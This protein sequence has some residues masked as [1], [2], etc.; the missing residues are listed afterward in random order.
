[1]VNPLKEQAVSKYP[2]T[3]YIPTGQMLF[4]QEAHLFFKVGQA[5]PLPGKILSAVVLI[6][7]VGWTGMRLFPWDV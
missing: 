1:M 7:A 2:N 3:I 4:T 6:Y 5:T